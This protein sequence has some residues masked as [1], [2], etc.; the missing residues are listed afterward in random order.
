MAADHF[1]QACR[2]PFANAFPLDENGLCPLCRRGMRGYDA[3]YSYGFYDGNLARLI[4]IYKYSAISTLAQPLSSLLSLALPRSERIDAIVPVPMHWFRRWTR[5]FDQTRLLAEEL[6]KRTGLPCLRV[7]S[8]TR[9][10]TPQAGLSDRE[11][12]KNVANSFAVPDAARVR[13][14]NILIIDDVLT[15]G[16][17]AS[18]CGLALKKAGARRVTAITVARADRR[19]YAPELT[20]RARSTSVGS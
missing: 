17:T 18:A 20:G 8:R 1:C 9:R 6:S 19:F 10:G 3:A 12:R 2:T 4:Q 16:A 5:G 7:L 11:R 14:K 15:T 13:G